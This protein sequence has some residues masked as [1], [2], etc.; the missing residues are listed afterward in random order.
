MRAISHAHVT[1][2]RRS[3]LVVIHKLIV[4]MFGPLYSSVDSQEHQGTVGRWG[5][6]T[7]PCE[8]GEYGVVGAQHALGRASEKRRTRSPR[9]HPTLVLL[10]CNYGQFDSAIYPQRRLRSAFRFTG[11]KSSSLVAKTW[12]REV[13]RADLLFGRGRVWPSRVAPNPRIL[14]KMKQE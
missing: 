11:S 12:L 7:S 10:A 13:S 9:Y 3:A 4:V 6:H 14:V 5:C 1:T 8:F 2:S